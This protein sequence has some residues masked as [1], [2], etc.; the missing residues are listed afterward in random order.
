MSTSNHSNSEKGSLKSSKGIADILPEEEPIVCTCEEDKNLC[1]PLKNRIPNDKLARSE[2][3][4]WTLDDLRAD[5]TKHPDN[6]RPEGEFTSK[7]LETWKPGERAPIVKRNDNL[8]LEGSFQENP[9]Y[10][11]SPGERDLD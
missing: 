6:L 2:Q 10:I 8:K 3:D 1:Y 5:I 4:K 7:P 9:P 11:W